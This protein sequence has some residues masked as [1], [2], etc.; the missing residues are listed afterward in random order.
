MCIIKM[1]E[2]FGTKNKFQVPERTNLREAKSAEKP[3]ESQI[4]LRIKNFLRD[5]RSKNLMTR[6]GPAFKL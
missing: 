4:I 6:K 2:K 5:F 3:V 1:I